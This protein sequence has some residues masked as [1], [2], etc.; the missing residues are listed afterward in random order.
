MGV[1]IIKTH[2]LCGMKFSENKELRKKENKAREKFQ[3]SRALDALT[4][5][6]SSVSS[7]STRLTSSLTLVPGNP[8]PFSDRDSH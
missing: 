3:A 7:T 8:T 1:D 2:C 4:E 5:D 6:S